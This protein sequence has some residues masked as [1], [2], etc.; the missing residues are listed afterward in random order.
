M[1]SAS[2]SNYE[3]L[4]SLEAENRTLYFYNVNGLNDKTIFETRR[5]YNNAQWIKYRQSEN[6][7]DSKK[8]L[9]KSHSY[10]YDIST[11]KPLNYAIVS[12]IYDNDILREFT[13]EFYF[14]AQK[15]ARRSTKYYDGQGRLERFVRTSFNLM[16]TLTKEEDIYIRD[17]NGCTV[18]V[19][20]FFIYESGVLRSK[21]IH[22]VDPSCQILGSEIFEYDFI[23]GAYQLEVSYETEI[24]YDENGHAI[25][26]AS[27]KKREGIDSTFVKLNEA[28]LEYDDNGNAIQVESFDFLSNAKT[29]SI[30]TYG[31]NSE[32][33]SAE[34]FLWDSLLMDW[35]RFLQS[36]YTYDQRG[37]ITQYKHQAIWDTTYQKFM[38]STEYIYRF[39]EMDQIIYTEHRE[40]DLR[41][42]EHP[43]YFHSESYSTY[44]CDGRLIE[45]SYKN[46]INRNGSTN[47][48]SYYDNPDC[49]EVSQ[50]IE[51]TLTV[52]PN[53]AQDYLHLKIDEVVIAPVIKVYNVNG[54]KVF[55]KTVGEGNFF[56]VS[57]ADLIPGIYF[58]K[59]YA[60]S[61]VYTQKIIKQ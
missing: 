56:S 30:Y 24:V 59:M 55:I 32:L 13:E 14:E 25:Y 38:A 10:D 57:I 27:L 26:S 35:S 17:E 22:N 15:E 44:A 2:Y 6:T 7:Y 41:D 39:N 58:V 12:Y 50:G 21:T 60:A 4:Q 29:L 52:F 40:E 46:L 51:R 20:S 45:S 8:R 18:E 42:P 34:T 43:N 37:N 31:P 28:V 19:W 11:G 61:E 47:V 54:E 16:R 5:F 36:S 49:K 9:I 33:R 48:F 1:K 3:D 23:S 53:P